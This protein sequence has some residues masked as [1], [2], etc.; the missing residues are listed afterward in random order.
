MSSLARKPLKA[1]PTPLRMKSIPIAAVMLASMLPQL[2]PMI[3]S[4]P[5]LPPLGLLVFLAWRL[6][7][8]ELW[9][10]WAALL[11]G[12]WDDLFSGQPIGSA[13]GLWGLAT[14]A[15]ELVDRR[16]YWRSF[17]QDWAIAAVTVL[18]IQFLGALIALGHL[19][20]LVPILIVLPQVIFAALLFPFVMRV[21]GG[22]DRVRLNH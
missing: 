21:V 3:A 4:S 19:A 5:L 8:P 9:P 22:L 2:L 12:L 17:L 1:P 15:I 7:R 14:L 10:L 11:F 20:A 18:A 13:M 6:L 16:L